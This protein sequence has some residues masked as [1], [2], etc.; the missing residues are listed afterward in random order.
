MNRMAEPRFAIADLLRRAGIDAQVKDVVPGA[1]GG[2]NRIYKVETSAGDFAAKFYFRHA[3]DSRD[4]L[5]AEY[6]FLTYAMAVAPGL[7]PRPVACSA[8]HGMALYEFIQGR[9]LGHEEIGVREVDSA[10]DF[11]QALNAKL[12]ASAFELP[13]ASEACF[14]ISDHLALISGRIDRLV[15]LNPLSPIDVEGAD[16]FRQIDQLWQEVSARIIDDARRR[17][18]DID[19]PLERRC[20]SPSDFGFHNALVADD[21]RIRFLDF[22]YAGWDDPAKAAGDFFAQLAVP[23][24]EEFFCRFLAGIAQGRPDARQITDRATLL[25]RAYKIKWCCIALNVFLPIH[26]A[27]RRFADPD[28][29]EA[30]VKTTQ[31]ERARQLLNSIHKMNDGLH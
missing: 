29:D 2:N 7:T 17:D 14:S 18:L 15:A 31:L 6:A 22:E 13:V 1:Y 27:R 24:P 12:P 21:G 10:I 5:A 30:A 8:E 9:R 4:R 25:R 26:L 11:F 23:V 19:A 28:L 20:I 16:F 3:E